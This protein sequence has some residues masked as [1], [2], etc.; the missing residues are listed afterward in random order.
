[1]RAWMTPL[2]EL[3]RRHD[4]KP[5]L[6]SYEKVFVEIVLGAVVGQRE[7]RNLPEIS[8]EVSGECLT[9]GPGVEV[10]IAG[11]EPRSPLRRQ[12]ELQPV[13]ASGPPHIHRTVIKRAGIK[14]E[15]SDIE[16]FCNSFVG[17]SQL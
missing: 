8:P 17:V 12:A 3:V 9:A 14:A 7:G 13:I 4:T 5:G 11:S 16:V 1:A 15:R 6:H 10:R 2:G